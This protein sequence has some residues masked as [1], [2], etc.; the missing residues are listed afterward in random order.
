M[1]ASPR[2]DHAGSSTTAP[3]RRGYELPLRADS[4]YSPPPTR[5]TASA[6]PLGDQLGSVRLPSRA[7]TLVCLDS[8]TRAVQ[9]A[10]SQSSHSGRTN[11]IRPV[12]VD[13]AGVI[14]TSDGVGTARRGRPPSAATT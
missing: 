1:M 12:A 9:T 4:A 10:A 2:G 6:L 3:A 7:E 13:H 11:A 5:T 8:S 14:G